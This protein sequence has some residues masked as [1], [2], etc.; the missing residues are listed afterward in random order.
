MPRVF[1]IRITDWGFSWGPVHVSRRFDDHKGLAITLETVYNR[2]QVWVTPR[3][4]IRV[5]L[6]TKR[7]LERFDN[8]FH[9][10]LKKGDTL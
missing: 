7:K 1:D 4:Y 3:G 10:N 5:A 9:A 8:V 6:D 2:L